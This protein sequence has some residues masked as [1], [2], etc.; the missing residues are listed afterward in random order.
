ML[1]L[2]DKFFESLWGD[3]VI[4]DFFG[5]QQELLRRWEDYVDRL[6]DAEFI[7]GDADSA[8]TEEDELE[9]AIKA[10]LA[11]YQGGTSS[12]SNNSR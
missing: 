11:E 7:D 10:S 9:R 6:F 12:G 8:L 2:A 5:F 4:E 1:A 3:L